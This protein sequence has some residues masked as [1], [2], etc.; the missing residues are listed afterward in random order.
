[1][2]LKHPLPP[3]RTYEQ[4]LNHYE[5]EKAIAARLMSATREE[6][7][8]IYAG[9]YD[10]L[11]TKVPDHSRLARRR[12]EAETR[13]VNRGKF[14]LIRRA[15]HR[16]TIFAEFA[17]G[18]CRFVMEVAPSVKQAI[19]IDISDQRNPAD[20]VP[21]NFRLIIY[22]GYDLGQL[23]DAGI[24]VLFSDQ[25]VEHFHPED[26]PLHFQT[27]SRILKKGG[28]YIFRTPHLFCG[29]HDVSK[30]FSDTPQGFHLKEWTYAEIRPVLKQAGFTKISA[31]VMLKRRVFSLPF[32]YFT[33]WEGILGRFSHAKI[34]RLAANLIR[35]IIIV[36][37]K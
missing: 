15:I 26:T 36:A 28:Q 18:D 19:G 35:E 17:P 13:R 10:E 9:M 12:D 24:D 20:P 8:V 1:M 23:P 5:V 25:L 34:R 4:I 16:S 14:A 21:E 27:A 37:V 30:Y 31:Q 7:K 32:F 29:P 11:F 3:G 33:A 22:D 6:R 2:Q